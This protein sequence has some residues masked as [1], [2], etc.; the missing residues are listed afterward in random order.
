LLGQHWAGSS[1]GGLY[2]DS[3]GLAGEQAL[4]AV[5]MARGC[6]VPDTEEQERWVLNYKAQA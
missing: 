6:P 5:E 4:I 3:P 1:Y 2:A